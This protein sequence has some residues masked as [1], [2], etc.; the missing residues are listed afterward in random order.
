MHKH[1]HRISVVLFFQQNFLLSQISHAVSVLVV[2]VIDAGSCLYFFPLT[3]GVTE[4]KN[5]V[6]RVFLLF[7]FLFLCSG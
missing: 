1:R 4:M 2:M 7:L 5:T 6:S 3:A